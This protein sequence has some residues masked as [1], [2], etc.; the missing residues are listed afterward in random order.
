MQL[1]STPGQVVRAARSGFRAGGV[2]Q[3]RQSA[4]DRDQGNFVRLAASSEALV[5]GLGGRLPA[6]G[7]HGRHV[8]Q[9]ARLGLPAADVHAATVLAGVPVEGSDAEQG[10]GL[11]AAELGHVGAEAPIPHS[12]KARA[13]KRPVE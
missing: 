12:T 2:E 7:N 10:G 13:S 8:E 9:V 1:S 6:D 3:A 4:H 5:T 11:A